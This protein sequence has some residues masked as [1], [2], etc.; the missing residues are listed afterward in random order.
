MGQE[1]LPKSEFTTCPQFSPA[2]KSREQGPQPSPEHQCAQSLRWVSGDRCNRDSWKM[3]LMQLRQGCE[4]LHSCYSV[5]SWD[6]V[7]HQTG[8]KEE[9][10]LSDSCFLSTSILSKASLVHSVLGLVPWLNKALQA[11]ELSFWHH[12]PALNS[13]LKRRK[14]KGRTY[15]LGFWH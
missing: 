6:H 14:Q 13:I 11:A 5:P 8:L 12:S 3:C 4:K 10:Q 2:S 9:V 15:L 7:L 1:S